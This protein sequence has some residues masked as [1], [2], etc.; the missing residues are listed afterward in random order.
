MTDEKTINP[1]APEDLTALERFTKQVDEL[2]PGVER[3]IC[4]R[5]DGDRETLAAFRL[6][7]PEEWARFWRYARTASVVDAYEDLAQSTI[8]ALAVAVRGVLP[9]PSKRSALEEW[10][11]L[12]EEYPGLAQSFGKKI[13]RAAGMT[14][15]AELL[16]AK[17]PPEVAK[18][19]AGMR[20]K[21]LRWPEENHVFALRA[22]KRAEWKRYTVE[23]GRDDDAG[24]VDDKPLLT[25]LRA[26]RVYPD[27]GTFDGLL[28]R[29]PGLAKAI[30]GYVATMAGLGSVEAG[31]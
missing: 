7:N 5:A 26:C 8:I 27:A 29:Y 13:Q 17:A 4:H 12:L 1:F 20:V 3:V 24:D 21:I 11:D 15:L 22:P 31:K 25:L 18:L 9:A 14:D 10:S 16:P 30:G 23:L 28:A 19:V 6:P 2:A